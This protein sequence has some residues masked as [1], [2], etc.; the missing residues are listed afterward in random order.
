MAGKQ[1]V[2]L[3]PAKASSMKQRLVKYGIG[4]AHRIYNKERD[5]RENP[6][7]IAVIVDAIGTKGKELLFLTP[8]MYKIAVERA[9][10]NPEDVERI[11]FVEQNTQS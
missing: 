11:L 4:R 5:N 2:P 7:Y 6:S 10:R 3:T 9:K 8:K 1:P